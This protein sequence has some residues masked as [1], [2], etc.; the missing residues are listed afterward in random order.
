MDDN[1]TKIVYNY[2]KTNSFQTRFVTG[3]IGGISTNGL[4]NMD[5][6]IDRVTIPQKVTHNIEISTGKISPNVVD[7][8]KKDGVVRE[9]HTGLIFDIMTAKSIITWMQ[10]K[11]QIIEEHQKKLSSENNLL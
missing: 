6:F 10:D 11:I 5:L 7:E 3:A 2:I 1:E 8:V 9:V 4:I